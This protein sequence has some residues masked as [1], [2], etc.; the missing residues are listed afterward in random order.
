MR[1]LPL[2]LCLWG[3]TGTPAVAGVSLD[4]SDSGIGRGDEVFR[5]ACNAC[6]GLKYL[7]MAAQLAAND[8]EKAFGKI[9]PDLSLIAAA[10]GRG[11]RGAR[12]VASLLLSYN[13]SPEKNSVFPGIA[14]PPVF[15]KND[16]KAEQKASDV[17]SFLYYASDPSFRERRRLGPWVLGYM[18]L[19]ATLLYLVYRRT[20]RERQGKGTPR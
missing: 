5:S 4:L 20:W 11:A 14:M 13:D 1:A 3:L 16:P 8:A 7:G 10:R 2:L 12:Y 15:A 9:P 19:L 6:H 18:A 17:A